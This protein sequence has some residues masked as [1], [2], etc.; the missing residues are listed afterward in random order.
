M[1][2]IFIR[3]KEGLISSL[4]KITSF[5]YH[6]INLIIITYIKVTFFLEIV[7]SSRFF[8]GFS[9][10]M[11]YKHISSFTYETLKKNPLPIKPPKT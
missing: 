11:T 6:H 9:M 2:S 7:A 4:L 8:G 3:K 1:N 5:F 10:K